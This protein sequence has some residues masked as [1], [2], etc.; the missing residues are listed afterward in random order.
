MAL[1]VALDNKLLR[2]SFRAVRSPHAAW[3]EVNILLGSKLYDA[4]A[5]LGAFRQGGGGALT[6]RG[7]FSKGW[8]AGWC[9]LSGREA[10]HT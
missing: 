5:L 10:L 1:P 8:R 9:D 3:R 7:V 2:L 6:G 4:A